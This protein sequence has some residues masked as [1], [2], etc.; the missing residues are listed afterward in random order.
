MGFTRIIQVGIEKPQC[1]IG[2][3]VLAVESMKLNHLQK[4]LKRLHEDIAEFQR[5]A[6]EMKSNKSE[7]SENKIQKPSYS[8]KRPGV[9]KYCYNNLTNIDISSI[10]ICY[11]CVCNKKYDF[12]VYPALCLYLKMYIYM[13]IYI[14]SSKLFNFPKYIIY[15]IVE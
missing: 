11:S 2:E 13:Y 9:H 7:A 1:V 14:F 10:L 5:L 4:H 15:A 6:E 8:G 12:P 3:K